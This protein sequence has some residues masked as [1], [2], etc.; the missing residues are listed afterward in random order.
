[1]SAPLQATRRRCSGRPRDDVLRVSSTGATLLRQATRRRYCMPTCLVL[2]ASRSQSSRAARSSKVEAL[3]SIPRSHSCAS[4]GGLHSRE[5]PPPGASNE[6][7]ADLTYSTQLQMIG[8]NTDRV[9]VQ[10][11]VSLSW[12]AVAQDREKWRKPA[13]RLVGYRWSLSLWKRNPSPEQA[14]TE[15]TQSEHAQPA[16]DPAATTW[17]QRLR[18][19]G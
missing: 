12:G 11:G 4:Q 9:A 8:F 13:A 5:L 6:F 2:N 14:R 16:L 19:R 1:V 7:V 10:R 15:R 18:S 17:S 3:S